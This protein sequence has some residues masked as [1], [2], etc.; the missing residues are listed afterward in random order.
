MFLFSNYCSDMFR[1]QFLAIFREL[2]AFLCEQLMRQLIWYKIYLY[3]HV[4]AI[5]NKQKHCATSWFWISYMCNVVARKMYNIK[6]LIRKC[7]ISRS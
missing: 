1:P 6:F 4:G 2:V 7:L 5:I 3:E